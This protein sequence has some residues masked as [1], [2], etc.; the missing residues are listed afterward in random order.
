MV[1]TQVVDI[2]AGVLMVHHT[3]STKARRVPMAPEFLRE[4][5]EWFNWTVSK[6]DQLTNE[7]TAMVK[8][9]VNPD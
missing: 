4:L 1:R 8:G 3:K 7:S 9:R 5:E 2:Q 6:T